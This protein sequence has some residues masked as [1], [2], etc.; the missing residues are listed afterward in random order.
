VSGHAK[1]GNLRSFVARCQALE[2]TCGFNLDRRAYDR[3]NC[4][5]VVPG[6]VSAIRKSAI[7]KAGGLSLETLAEDTDLT[8][9]LHKDRQRIVYVPEA[10]AWTEAP[11]SMRT[12]ARQRF[13]WAYGTLQCL[14]KH[15]DLVFNSNHG[16][17]GWF[18]LPSVW[19]FQIILVAITPMVDLFLLVSLP[20]GAWRDL[21]P[22]VIAFLS[23]DLIL[24]TLACIL[25]R[26]P[27]TRA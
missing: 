25:E 27:I 16:A 5:T 15:R 23:M 6:A 7:D 8:L 26:E 24:A 3:W 13:R 9:A 19:F 12:L 22:F 4:I 14:W 1:V 20:F 18:S 2:Y 17:L 21:L 11:E 10:I